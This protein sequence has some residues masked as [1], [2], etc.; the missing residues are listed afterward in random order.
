MR[1]KILLIFILVFTSFTQSFSQSRGCDS[2]AV[3]TIIEEMPKF[4]DGNLEAFIKQNLTVP[5]VIH[6]EKI[7][8]NVY[9]AFIICADGTIES[10]RVLRGIKN[11]KQCDEEAI[12]VVK[13]MPKWE[14]GKQRGTPMAVQ[15]NLPVRFSPKKSN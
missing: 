9:V 10:I 14:P 7:S 11:C 2:G 5:D 6:K 13:M 15:Y 3:Y 1:F 12:K 8:G 4:P